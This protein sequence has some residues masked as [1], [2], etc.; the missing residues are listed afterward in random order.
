MSR[1]ESAM[2]AYL[3]TFAIMV[4]MNVALFALVPIRP[5]PPLPEKPPAPHPAIVGDW[6]DEGN[7]NLLRITP[8][9]TLFIVGGNLNNGDGLTAAHTIDWNTN[10]YKIELR[11]RAQPNRLIPGV[12]KLEGDRL[13]LALRTFP[14]APD[15]QG[16][17]DFSNADTR[18]DYR[19]VGK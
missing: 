10:P 8:T 7:S 4:T 6:Q 15:K 18:I 11:P 3:M 16:S 9:E 12:F 19:R 17:L 2:K 14:P 5:A 1:S 13:R